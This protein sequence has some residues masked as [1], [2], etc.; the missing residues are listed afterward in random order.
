LEPFNGTLGGLSIEL[1]DDRKFGA[2]GGTDCQVSANVAF[3]VGGGGTATGSSEAQPSNTRSGKMHVARRI[4]IA[5]NTTAVERHVASL[6]GLLATVAY[7]Q[8]ARH[9]MRRAGRFLNLR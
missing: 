9:R 7:P 3:K 1:S 8:Q 6:A 2:S 4:R 5:D